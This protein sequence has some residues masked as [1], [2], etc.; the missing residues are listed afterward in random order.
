[1][2]TARDLLIKKATKAGLLLSEERTILQLYKLIEADKLL[3]KVTIQLGTLLRENRRSEFPPSAIKAGKRR[4]NRTMLGYLPYMRHAGMV[5]YKTTSVT[6]W[7][8]DH[9]K[10]MLMFKA[11]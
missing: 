4:G 7:Y 5:Y 11:V 1:M 10:R 8:I 9:L 3:N 6:A 2:K